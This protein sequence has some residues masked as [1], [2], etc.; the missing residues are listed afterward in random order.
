MK[1][2]LVALLS[3]YVFSHAILTSPT[4]RR[5]GNTSFEG[6]GIKVV[7]FPMTDLQKSGCLDSVPIAPTSTFAANAN[8]DVNW[9]ITLP[10]TS[11]PGVRIAIQYPNQPMQVLADNLDVN[12]KTMTVSAPNKTG[13][14]VIQWYWAS[15]EDGG[16]YLACSDVMITPSKKASSG[17]SRAKSRSDRMQVQAL[18]IVLIFA[19]LL[20]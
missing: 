19:C 14:A 1:L 5:T 3:S 8:I 7:N 6:L 13:Y 18:A 16:F 20:L 17:P 12:L 10:H 15:E 11:D 2:K 9:E 4:P